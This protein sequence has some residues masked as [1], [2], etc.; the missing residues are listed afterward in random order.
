[1]FELNPLGVTTIPFEFPLKAKSTRPLYD[2]YHGVFIS[3]QYTLHAE[4]RR[5][6]L[7]KPLLKSLEFIMEGLFIF[8]SVSYW[9]SFLTML[10]KN[11]AEFLN[12]WMIP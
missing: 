4:L 7:N 6:I 2:S 10:W 12:N 3:V 1:M 8:L 11:G 5:G 9:F